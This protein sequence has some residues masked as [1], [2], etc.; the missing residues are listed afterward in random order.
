MPVQLVDQ[1]GA[2]LRPEKNDLI[3]DVMIPGQLHKRR[4]LGTFPDN[5]QLR[6]LSLLGE[7]SQGL[8][9]QIKALVRNQAAQSRQII[10]PRGRCANLKES[11]VVRVGNQLRLDR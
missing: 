2:G 10:Q 8:D 6:P 1:F 11:R 3:G 7:D 4:F 9:Q 5:G